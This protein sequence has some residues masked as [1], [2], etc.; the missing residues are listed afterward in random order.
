MHA[1]LAGRW[2]SEFMDLL[3]QDWDGAAELRDA[4]LKSDLRRWTAGLTGAVVRSF[5]SLGFVCAAKGHKLEILP[6]KNEEYLGM[7]VS[8]FDRSPTPRWQFPVAVCEL[9][10]SARG[11]RVAYS[12]WKVMSV[13]AEMRVVF[14]Y[15]ASPEDAL[16]LVSKLADD[17]VSAMPIQDRA[18]LEGDILVVTGCR[19]ESETFPYGFFRVWKLDVNTGSFGR[20]AQER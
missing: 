11:D 19:G 15:R 18:Q 14:C 20:F 3:R 12:L 10:N 8:V 6:E 5:E 2:Y 16:P 7:D 1:G 17:V 13:R 9:E 4:S